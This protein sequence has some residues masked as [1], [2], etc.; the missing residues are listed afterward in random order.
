MSDFQEICEELSYR[1]GEIDLNGKMQT[2]LWG[3]TNA[4]MQTPLRS[5]T[6]AKM[7]TALWG[8]A[9]QKNN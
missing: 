9:N 6:N 4:K 1:V 7:Q 3:S 8:S 2:A 5:C